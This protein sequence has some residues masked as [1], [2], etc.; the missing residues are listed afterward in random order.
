MITTGAYFKIEQTD[1][2]G[3]ADIG[4]FVIIKIGEVKFELTY[5]MAAE[6]AHRLTAATDRKE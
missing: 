5:D 2:M 3:C 6:L 4:K 1:A